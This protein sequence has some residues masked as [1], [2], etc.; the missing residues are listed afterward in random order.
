MKYLSAH[1]VTGM[2]IG[3]ATAMNIPVIDKFIM[4]KNDKRFLSPA[5]MI[6]CD[7]H[8]TKFD[9]SWIKLEVYY[10]NESCTVCELEE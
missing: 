2:D 7:K 3:N 8:L 1:V 10:G 9:P 4:Q 5:N 6:C